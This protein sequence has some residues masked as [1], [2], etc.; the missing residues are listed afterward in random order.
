MNI[1][2]ISKR[3]NIC[4]Y[5]KTLKDPIIC[6]VGTRK[7]EFFDK[8]FTSN[9]SLGVMVDIW[10][11]TGNLY[12]NDNTYTQIDLN[13]QYRH[14]F[15]KFLNQHNIKIIREFSH[16]ASTF[17]PDNFFDFIYIDADHSKEGCYKDLTCWYPKVKKGGI[18]SGHD[19]ISKEK[20]II[21]GHTVEFGVI[22]AVKEFREL[23]NITDNNFHLTSEE[24]AT[25]FIIKS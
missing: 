22:E 18:I 5:I 17:F 9:C 15:T 8:L 13:E 12:Q 3:D 14:V 25:F 2:N 24:Y 21:Y 7:G 6:E 19:H 11:D 20:T 16:I 23:N 4:Q 1:Y 10:M